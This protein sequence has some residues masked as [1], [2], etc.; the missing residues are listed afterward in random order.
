[1]ETVNKETQKSWKTKAKEKSIKIKALEKE[2][3][4][5]QIQSQSYRAANK[6]LHLEMDAI[7]SEQTTSCLK[8]VEITIPNAISKKKMKVV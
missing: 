6:L 4:R 7:R 8:M 2:K 5:L 1:M 3:K